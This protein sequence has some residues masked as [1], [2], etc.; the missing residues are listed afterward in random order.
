MFR[1]NSK[2][3]KAAARKDPRI[4]EINFY[5]DGWVP[6][7]YRWPSPGVMLV[8]RRNG[9]QHWVLHSEKKIDRKR[10]HGRGPKWVA[11]SAAGGRLASS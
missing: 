7:S 1:L 3:A 11:L 5:P 10:H 4:V 8:Y 6:M 2:S 9:A